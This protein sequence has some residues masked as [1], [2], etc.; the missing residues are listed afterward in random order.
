MCFYFVLFLL[1]PI[2]KI[3]KH[4]RAL[5]R[6][7]RET[8]RILIHS[9]A[10]QILGKIDV[11]INDMTVDYL[12][13]VGHKV[14]SFF[15]FFITKCHKDSIHIA[16]ILVPVQPCWLTASSEERESTSLPNEVRFWV[17]Y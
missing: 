12:T 5:K 8:K 17:L 10:A 13:I 6:K 3:C 7:S 11:D 14:S 2:A 1:Q 15:L 4:V 9:D 16:I